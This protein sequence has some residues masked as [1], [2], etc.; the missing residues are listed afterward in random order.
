LKLYIAEDEHHYNAGLD[1]IDEMLEAIQAEDIEDP[2][3]TGVEALFKLLKVL[4]E[5][6]HEHIEVTHLAFIT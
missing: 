2:P 3:T 6:L 4:E 1:R 5:L